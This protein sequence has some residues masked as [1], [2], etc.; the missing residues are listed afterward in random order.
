[1]FFRTCLTLALAGI[2]S[3]PFYAHAQTD[4]EPAFNPNMMLVLSGGYAGSQFEPSSPATGFAMNPHPFRERGFNLGESELA[5]WAN[6]DTQY[7]GTATFALDPAGG[8]SVENAFVQTSSLGEGF[9]LKF[10]R[11]FSGLGYLNAQHAHVWDF[12]DQP[13]VYATF[14]GNQLGDDGV[15]LKWLAPTETYIEFGAELGKGRGFPGS[16]TPQNRSGANTLFAHVGSDIGIEQSWQVGLSLHRTRA[17]DRISDNVPD[18][19]GNFVSNAFSGSSRTVGLDFVW[20]YAPNGNAHE[21]QLKLQ[22]EFF[23]RT[24]QGLLTYDTAVANIADTYT[25]TQN[26]WYVQ[27]VYQFS[28]SWRSGLRYDRL[29]PGTAQIGA[30]NVGNLISQYAYQPKRVSWMLEYSA[31]EFSRLRLQWA[32]DESRQG[33]SG[34][35]VMVQYIMSMGAHGAHAF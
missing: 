5:L 10:G 18:L 20:K 6:I 25:V 9:S 17:I 23:R 14:W 16:D 29:D 8:L 35:Q 12:A 4:A 7:R 30:A 1:M 11:F 15:Q 28:P 26:G 21:R 2:F 19:N 34:N 22:A 32:R 27:G 33:L 31:S 13:L 24:E 3:L